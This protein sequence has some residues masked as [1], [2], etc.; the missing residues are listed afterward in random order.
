MKKVN[1][2]IIGLILSSIFIIINPNALDGKMVLIYP[3]NI[4]YGLG[5][6][7]LSIIIF[8]IKYFLEHSN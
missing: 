3:E 7:F 6:I 1:K 4:Y 8:F 2:L 5:L